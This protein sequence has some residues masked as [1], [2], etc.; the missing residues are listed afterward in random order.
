MGSVEGIGEGSVSGETRGKIV[1]NLEN[2]RAQVLEE[3]LGNV[4]PLK[5]RAVWYWRQRDK[6]SIAWLLALPG[7]D[8]IL[9]NADFQKQ[10]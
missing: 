9:T 2:V 6:V 4:R 10:Q 5:T 8:T 7:V 1:E 3:A